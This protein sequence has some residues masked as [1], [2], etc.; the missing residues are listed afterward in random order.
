MYLEQIRQP[1]DIKKYTVNELK[2]LAVEMRQA[3]MHRLS[4][5]GGHFGPN[6]EW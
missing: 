6:F 3:L 4:K 1:Q 5:L 2:E